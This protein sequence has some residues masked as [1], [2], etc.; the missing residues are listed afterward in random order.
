[1]S[2]AAYGYNTTPNTSMGPGSVICDGMV[3]GN[4][5]TVIATQ[6]DAALCEVL[7]LSIATS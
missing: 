2:L 1:M 6:P 5:V 3:S 4:V 7:G